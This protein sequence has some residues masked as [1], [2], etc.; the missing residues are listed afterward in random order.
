G[1]STASQ[2]SQLEWQSR[3]RSQL[4]IALLF[5][6]RNSRW[7]AQFDMRWRRDTLPACSWPARRL[8]TLAHPKARRTCSA[9]TEFESA[10]DIHLYPHPCARHWLGTQ[11]LRPR[12]TS[13]SLPRSS[14]L[15]PRARVRHSGARKLDARSALRWRMQQGETSSS[16]PP[17]LPS[18][19]AETERNAPPAL[20]IS[21][22]AVGIAV[23]ALDLLPA[24]G[25][26]S[27]SPPSSFL[28]LA[29]RL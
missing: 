4:H 13:G 7:F 26:P 25:D 3:S 15:L 29:T 21:T 17:S 12:S 20:C 24:N 16:L 23:A 1:H 18:P 28:A 19:R 5:E 11:A 6:Y 27:F 22:P 9:S 2:E 8:R 10:L 14:L